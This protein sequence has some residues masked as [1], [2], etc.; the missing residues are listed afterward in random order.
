MV[1]AAQAPGEVLHPLP[2][3]GSPLG[4]EGCLIFKPCWCL[5]WLRRQRVPHYH[6]LPSPPFSR[7]SSLLSCGI[8][9]V[10][11]GRRRAEVWFQS[12]GTGD[13]LLPTS[14]TGQ[15]LPPQEP[16]FGR[17]EPLALWPH[18]PITGVR[19]GCPL[20]VQ[21]SFP[22]LQAL[23]EPLMELSLSPRLLRGRSYTAARNPD[24]LAPLRQADTG[25]RHEAL[26]VETASRAPCHAQETVSCQHHHTTFP[27][28]HHHQELRCLVLMTE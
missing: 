21:V 17:D 25:R 2:G 18:L 15:A 23:A 26:P 13:L 3:Q 24:R 5:C 10:A 9:A 4:P 7:V 8:V 28:H 16:V 19:G 12:L 6:S 22:P 1:L 14:I 27:H 20:E 11:P